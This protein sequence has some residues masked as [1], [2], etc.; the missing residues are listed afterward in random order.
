LDFE[1]LLTGARR[2]A[3][4]WIETISITLLAAALAYWADPSNPLFIRADFPWLALAPALLALRYGVLPG[5][6]SCS[7]L[8][9]LWVIAHRADLA[10]AVT[11]TLAL[12]GM[13]LLTMICGEFSS[14]WTGRLRRLEM[15]NRYLDERLERITRQHYLL[16][17]SHARLEQ[18]QFSRPVTLRAA[19]ARIRTLAATRAGNEGYPGLAELLELLGQ[20]CQLEVASFHAC[21]AGVPESAVLQAIGA[22]QPLAVDDPLVRYCLDK[23]ELSHVQMEELRGAAHSRYLIVAPVLTNEGRLVALLA[24]EQMPFLA[25]HAE[26]LATLTVLLGYYADA[27]AVSRSALVMQ[28]ALPGCPLEF[29]DEL[30]RCQ[31]MWA[32]AQVYSS[33]LLIKFGPHPDADAY[34]ALIRRQ[35]RDLDLVWEIPQPRGHVFLT[36]LPLAG[37]AGVEGCLARLEAS[38]DQRHQVNF[39]AAHIAPYGQ[40]LGDEDPFITV[41]LMLENYDVRV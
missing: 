21:K 34:A 15:S 3:W 28:R 17:L 27:L 23:R 4:E 29:A 19:L 18:D 37:P 7:I 2:P 35:F 9:A 24:V 1:R 36:L 16:M 33:L 25:L 41:Q 20:F 12:V 32:E 26:A 10:P 5:L 22:A 8:T 39:D 6:A 14:L 31:R 40:Q 13:L 30:S 38:L 11:P